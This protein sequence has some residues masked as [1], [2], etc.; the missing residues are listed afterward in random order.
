[1]IHL[2]NFDDI[3]GKPVYIAI[4]LYANQQSWGSYVQSETELH[5]NEESCDAW[6]A[7]MKEARAVLYASVHPITVTCSRTEL[8]DGLMGSLNAERQTIRAEFSEQ[9]REV[10][11]RMSK[12]LA[13]SHEAPAQPA[14][15]PP[16]QP[17]R[18]LLAIPTAKEYVLEVINSISIGENKW[19]GFPAITYIDEEGE[20]FPVGNDELYPLQQCD[21]EGYLF[22]WPNGE[23]LI[24]SLV[25]G[26]DWD[27]TIADYAADEREVSRYASALLKG[28]LQ[29][30]GE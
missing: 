1:M 2:D 7:R 11:E 12:L 8:H 30:Y 6:V 23:T 21:A 28:I 13:I 18:K 26:N 29:Q 25:W 4:I 16:E 27:E 10:E 3:I 9:L 24:L 15:I 14:Y 5:E 22:T 17:P 20:H 19:G